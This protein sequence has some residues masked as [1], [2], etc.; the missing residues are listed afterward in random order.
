MQTFEEFCAKIENTEHRQRFEALLEKIHN[1]FPQLKLEMKWNK[2][3]FILNNKFIIGFYVSKNHLS[4]IPEVSTLEHFKPE[5]KVANYDISDAERL[6]IIKW[7]DDIN[8]Q[9]ISEIIEYNIKIKENSKTFWL[10]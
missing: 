6:I 5:I 7:A 2:P 1:T 4:V 9:L 3:M 10:S 8:F